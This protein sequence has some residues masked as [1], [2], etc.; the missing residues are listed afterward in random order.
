[1]RGLDTGANLVA[2]QHAVATDAAH[3]GKNVQMVP[4][5]H[6]EFTNGLPDPG[7]NYKKDFHLANP[8]I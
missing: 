7:L 2:V 3:M 4:A 6:P 1:V 5:L 8:F